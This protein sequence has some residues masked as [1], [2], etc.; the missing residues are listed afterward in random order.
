ME[1]DFYN[2]PIDKFIILWLILIVIGAGIVAILSIRN[3]A[4]FIRPLGELT[5]TTTP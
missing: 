5:A 3:I 4:H 1:E 2:D